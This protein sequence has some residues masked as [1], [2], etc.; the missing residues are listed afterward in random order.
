MRKVITSANYDNSKVRKTLCGGHSLTIPDDTLSLKE[1]IKR[2]VQGQPL[3]PMPEL[4]DEMVTFDERDFSQLD[5]VEQK[6]LEDEITQ[7]I[8]AGE[9]KLK[10]IADGI[11]KHRTAKANPKKSKAQPLEPEV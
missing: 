2:A 9:S 5:I 4:A 6:Q 8:N 10:D 11:V 3:P 7:K 1:I